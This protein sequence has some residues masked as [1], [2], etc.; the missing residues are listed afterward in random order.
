MAYATVARK[1]VQTKESFPE[2]ELSLLSQDA[3]CLDQQVGVSKLKSHEGEGS[4]ESC[5]AQRCATGR[6]S[7]MRWSCGW[8]E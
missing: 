3:W 2:V 5:S 1:Q 6:D 4:N 7:K 8:W